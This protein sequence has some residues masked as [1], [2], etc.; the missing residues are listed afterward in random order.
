M[1]HEQTIDYE[2]VPFRYRK[3]HEHGHLFI[4]FPL[5]Q[6]QPIE[7]SK[8]DPEGFTKV[9][10]EKKLT[11]KATQDNHSVSTIINPS[12]SAF[13]AIA[14]IAS[15]RDPSDDEEIMLE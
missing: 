5:N 6:Q 3:C 7:S 12:A 10:H 14:N 2:H 4:N 11:K 13:A 8:Q 15:Y 9:Q 1:E